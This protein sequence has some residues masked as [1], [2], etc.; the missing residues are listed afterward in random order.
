MVELIFKL[1]TDQTT[2][3]RIDQKCL[4]GGGQALD[5]E[6][7]LTNQSALSAENTCNSLSAPAR[8]C[9]PPTIATI[10]SP[11]PVTI[12]QMTTTR[13]PTQPSPQVVLPES[14]PSPMSTEEPIDERPVIPRN[15]T[16]SP[17]SNH[18]STSTSTWNVTTE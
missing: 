12:Q 2:C 7:P 10:D 1:P 18:I 16:I 8:E 6:R 17:S 9:L 4:R 15:P 3:E 5:A 14:A 11:P 13:P